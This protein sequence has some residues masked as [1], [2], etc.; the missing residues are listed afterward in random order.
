MPSKIWNAA[1]DHSSVGPTA[2][3]RGSRVYS[4]ISGPRHDEKH[5]RRQD[6]E[7][8]ARAEGQPSR[9]PRPPSPAPMACPTPPL[10]RR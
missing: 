5:D 1:A 6:H 10:P 8:G 7:A 2:S 3:T 4:A 9:A